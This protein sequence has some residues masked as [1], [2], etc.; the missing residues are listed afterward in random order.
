MESLITPKTPLEEIQFHIYDLGTSYYGGSQ[1]WFPKK[2]HQ[3]SGCGPVAAAN[4]TAYLSQTFPDKYSNLYSYKGNINK[5]DF[6]KHMVEIRK[7]VKP[8]I[9]GLTSV[10]QF[11]DN[12][13]DFSKERGVSL[14]P[15]ILNGNDSSIDE[16]II[17]ISEALSQKIPVAILVLKHPV[18]E[19]KEYTW[20]WMTITGLNMNYQDN[21]YYISVSSYGVREEINLDLLWNRRRSKHI[22][23]LAYFA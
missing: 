15:H 9:F 22:I 3:L 14:V 12:V 5:N 7:Y 13:M 4:I 10:N 17:F 16:A 2:F 6:V 1:Y 18:K 20:H 8:G 11:S 23:S 19:F 21:I